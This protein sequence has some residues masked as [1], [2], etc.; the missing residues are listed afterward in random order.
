MMNN[1]VGPRFRWASAP[2]PKTERVQRSLHSLRGQMRLEGEARRPAKAGRHDYPSSPPGCSKPTRLPENSPNRRFSAIGKLACR[3][4]TVGRVFPGALGGPRPESPG[5]DSRWGAE[6][7]PNR[8]FS[9][10]RLLASKTRAAL[11]P[12]ALPPNWADRREARVN[13]YDARGH[14]KKFRTDNISPARLR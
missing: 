12:S 2:Q 9:A 3:K 7:S 10:S 11:S 13:S 5:R 6:N 4:M 8:H 14:S 1:A